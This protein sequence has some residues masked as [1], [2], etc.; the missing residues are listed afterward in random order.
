MKCPTQL[1]EQSLFLGNS[2]DFVQGA[3]G[4]LSA[5]NDNVMWIK[6]SGTRLKDAAVNPIFLPMDL[7]ATHKEVIRSENLLSCCIPTEY[8]E[9]LRPSIETAIHSL[10]PHKYVAHVHSLGAISRAI[11][12]N[13]SQQL[14]VLEVDATKVFIPYSKPGIPL[15]NE[16]MAQIRTQ[17]IDSSQDLV[18][19]LG[20][21]GLIVASEDISVATKLI[22][23]IEKVWN[24]QQSLS[25]TV[26]THLGN[27]S[28]LFPP[29]TLDNFQA[30]ILTGGALTP[31]EVVFLGT[32]P[33]SYLSEP[34]VNS[35]VCISEDGSV[36][37]D[38]IL[39]AD[40]IEIVVSF[41]NIARLLA[42]GTN[43]VYLSPGQVEELL[44]W[45]AE[46]WRKAQEK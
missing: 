40:A 27:L 9:G 15:A 43:P 19:L 21:H 44:N 10:L 6:A 4:N 32:V 17:K 34:E 13:A 45:D 7:L 28:M 18:V 14:E 2:T 46:K 39:S 25:G 8:S 29:S 20:N 5:K 1:I 36:W 33:F 35:K 3:G 31:D 24:P 42:P 11:S 37:I 22:I 23:S 16:I 12:K 30:K 41:V 38:S 26:G